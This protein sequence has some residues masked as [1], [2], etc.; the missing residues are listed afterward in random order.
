M[1]VGMS[2]QRQR[3]EKLLK[4]ELIQEQSWGLSNAALSR[5]I[6]Q[7]VKK[8]ADSKNIIRQ[9][10][11][12]CL[13]FMNE[14]MRSGNQKENNFIALILPYLN[15]S[16]NWHIREE[17]LNLLI[18]CFLSSRDQ[19]EFDCYQILDSIL[20]LLNDTKEKIRSL[21]LE[22]VAAFSSIGPHNK[23]SEVMFQLNIDKE[24]CEV[25]AQRLEQ[26]LYPTVSAETG[27]I[28]LPYQELF[29]HQNYDVDSVAHS[30]AN[31]TQGQISQSNHTYHDHRRKQSIGSGSQ[32]GMQYLANQNQGKRGNSSGRKIVVATA[33]ATNQQLGVSHQDELMQQAFLQNKRTASANN[34]NFEFESHNLGSFINGNNLL[35]ENGAQG[36][37]VHGAAFTR[38]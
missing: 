14:I 36:G 7:I 8:L 38:G 19:S 30:M 1:I 33:N 22:A 2:Q 15:N 34:P 29:N 5:H 4:Q 16:S 21:A 9:E 26:G 6:P 28:E 32:K 37:S 20:Q 27:N 13:F 17:L 11:V 12:R 10:A 18:R 31:Q 3:F 23:L 35:S 25:V 24:I